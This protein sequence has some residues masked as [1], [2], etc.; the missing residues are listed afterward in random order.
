MTEMVVSSDVA[1]AGAALILDGF[2]RYRVRFD[3][4]TRRAKVRFD[5]RE[6]SDMHADMVERLE[7]YRTVID[8]TEA[9]VR[10]YLGDGVHDKLIWAQMQLAYLQLVF[11]RPDRELSETFFNSVT[12]RV[13][14]TVGVDAQIEFVDTDFEKP[15]TPAPRPVFRTY[16]TTS[17]H[18]L[19]QAIL[20]DYQFRS[21]Y[22]DFEGD[23]ERASVRLFPDGAA[24]A[25]ADV[26]RA[27]F[28]RGH[29]AYL[30]GR[31]TTGAA[32]LPFA[33]ALR[34]TEQGVVIDA[35]LSG[36]DDL[37][38]LFSLTRSYFHAEIARPHDL[39]EFIH[40]L[41]PHRRLADIYISLGFNK[42]G[43]T[44]LYRDLLR[45][46]A[47]SREAFDIAPGTPGLVMTAFTMPGL[48]LIFKIIRDRFPPQKQT[49]RRTVR[50][51]YRLVFRHDRAGRL[52]DAQ[53]FEHLTFE[54]WRFT[55]RLLG[56]LAAEA[57][58]T[59]EIGEETVDIRH[60]YVERK[61][62]P[63]DLFLR[64]ED[65]AACRAAVLDYGNAIKD[66]A[67]TNIFPG[68]LLLKNFGVNRLGRVVF[69]D[70]DELTLLT[71][72]TFRRIPVAQHPDD[73]MSADAW[74]GVSEGDVFPEEFRNFLGMRRDLRELF[75][76][77]HAEVF[78]PDFW[79]R[80]QERIKS[81]EL[82]EIYPYPPDRRL[83]Q[84]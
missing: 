14:A 20:A 26:A 66:L 78:D 19:L 8:A 70:Y 32:P 35:A 4:I 52:I 13:F 31:I 71:D 1:A 7:L 59:V 55:E 10:G 61:L 3:V 30:V 54:R 73:E 82:I 36:T 33:L 11:T 72:C 65:A 76:R 2:E 5:R 27:V 50:E 63:L 79:K 45:D 57:S 28:F 39:V 69:Y 81:G 48:D 40:G 12:R 17:P 47:T 34:N 62:D 41:L 60:V 44:E 83:R 75:E 16:R 25:A 22:A 29:G 21:P 58:D 43:K 56:E 38:V 23:A 68:D 64:R 46:L 9:S 80:I 77:E 15:L 84:T 6:W 53:E 49:T 24:G 67:A 18:A 51:K 37:S 74:F 42:H